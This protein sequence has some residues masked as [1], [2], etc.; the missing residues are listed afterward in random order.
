M[1]GTRDDLELL[2]ASAHQE[3]AALRE[4]PRVTAPFAGSRGAALCSHLLDLLGAVEH[5]I[6]GWP[7]AEAPRAVRQAF[8][9]SARQSILVLRGAHA[10]LPWLAATRTPNVN[11]GSL[12]VTEELAGILVGKDVDL[13][14]VPDPEF[15]YSTTSWP[16]G[17]VIDGTDGFDPVTKRRPIVLNYPLTDSDRLLLHPVFAHELGHAS[18][19][20]HKLTRQ[21]ETRLEADPGFM[22]ALSEVVT[23]MKSVWPVAT[24]TQ[25]ASTVRAWLRAWIEELLCD[26]LALET[27]GPAFVWAFAAFAMPL[28]YGKPGQVHPPN[29]VRVRLALDHLEDRGWRDFLERVSPEVTAW[30]DT[31]ASDAASPM[32]APFA[33]L[34]DQLVTNASVLQAVAAGCV[35]GGLLNREKCEAEAEEAAELLDHLIL[36]VGLDGVLSPRSIILGGWLGAIKRHGDRPKAI[37]NAL[38][39]RQLQELVGKAIE[40]STVT[41]AWRKAI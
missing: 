23:T 37:V 31:I 22:A 34:R 4:D 17:D 19:N 39:D 27:M 5:R 24:T 13:V 36:P 16:F 2:L 29:T 33:F 41:D 7:D 18:V 20:E 10:A 3:I 26:Y 21:V 30:L 35:K 28:A 25:T 1:D 11:L 14:V 15:M 38:A 6:A 40:M 12:Y 8:A 32:P 9:R